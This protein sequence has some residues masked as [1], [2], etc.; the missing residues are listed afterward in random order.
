MRAR[1]IAFWILLALCLP[2]TSAHAQETEAKSTNEAAA[3][4]GAPLGA[5]MEVKRIGLIDLDG[6]LRQSGGLEKV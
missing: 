6:V 4:N 2:M 5:S 3:A 1:T